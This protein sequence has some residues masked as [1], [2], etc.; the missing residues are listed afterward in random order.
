MRNVHADS[1]V[2]LSEHNAANAARNSAQR[3]YVLLGEPYHLS[4]VCRDI[5]IR[6]AVGQAYVDKLIT[7]IKV[8]GNLAALRRVLVLHNIGFLYNTVPCSHY[9]EVIFLIL[10]YR[11]HCRDFLA[12]LKP[13]QVYNRRTL[14]LSARLGNLVR[15]KS[16]HPSRIGKEQ[17]MRMGRGNKHRVY[18]VLFLCL[19]TYYA[20]AA[21]F[22][23]LVGI[24]RKTLDITLVRHRDYVIL[25]SNQ[26]LNVNIVLN[27]LNRRS[28]L[29]TEFILDFGYLV[30]KD[31]K[32]HM[33]ILQN[34]GQIC[35]QLHQLVIFL[36]DFLALQTLQSCKTH[37]KYRLCLNI[38]ERKT[39]NK[40][41]LCIVVAP[42]DNRNY[43]VYVVKS[44]PQSFKDMCPR[45]RLALVK[46]RTSDNDLLLEIN[47]VVKNL[48]EVKYLWLNLIYKRKHYRAE[49]ILQLRVLVQLIQ[50][51]CRVRVTLQ[52][53]YNA[54]TVTVGLVAQ[55]GDSLHP[56]FV[57]K[58]RNALNQP[59]L[60][61]HVRYLR[62]HKPLSALAVFLY[63][64]S[65]AYADF[66]PA[67]VVYGADSAL[68]HYLRAGR[69]V[70]ALD[71]LHKLVYRDFRIVDNRNNTVN[72]LGEVV[73]R[74]IRSHADRN[75][76][77]AV[78]QK[79]RKP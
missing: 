31:F 59:C 4:E 41:L 25:L 22:L 52:L 50:Y 67:R 1:V 66:A 72:Y 9:K 77:R 30:F 27:R 69:E 19:H 29:V 57:N 24:N 78:Y 28:S 2:T 43:F 65:R 3:S 74:N 33:L 12:R 15:F 39:L 13:E 68:A 48:A 44:Y 23:T 56:L 76:V 70:R 64:H 55:V 17:N 7:L 61:Y 49:R 11:Y 45:L 35:N 75:T 32:H 73:R 46:F 34:L 40:V 14:C 54:H 5:N 26:V 6:I 16:V 51:D 71:V 18:K 36:I 53:D 58:L 60:V 8:N 21:A 20:L 10:S 42:A 62:N 37:I 38:R 63:I 79:M 47:V